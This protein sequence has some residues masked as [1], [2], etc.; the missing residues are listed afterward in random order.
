M[1]SIQFL[2]TSLEG[3]KILS[4]GIE[5]TGT[6][7]WIIT[8]IFTNNR[9]VR[10]QRQPVQVRVPHRVH[11]RGLREPDRLLPADPAVWTLRPVQQHA[12]QLYLQLL[13]GLLGPQLRGQVGHVLVGSLPEWGDVRGRDKPVHLCVYGHVPGGQLWRASGSVSVV[14]VLQ[15]R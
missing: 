8:Q 7:S 12:E 11:G 5:N 9:Y 4:S 10:A 15:W 2:V 1:K 6:Y 3:D 13:H 14:R